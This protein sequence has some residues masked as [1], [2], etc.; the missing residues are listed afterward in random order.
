MVWTLLIHTEDTV[1][2]FGIMSPLFWLW[3]LQFSQ[4]NEKNMRLI[5]SA[6]NTTLNMKRQIKK[7]LSLEIINHYYYYPFD[8]V[9]VKEKWAV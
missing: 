7:G 1:Y 3:C 9:Y 5:P 2:L 8:G 6:L 4:D